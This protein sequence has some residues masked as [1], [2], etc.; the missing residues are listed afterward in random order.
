MKINQSLMLALQNKLQISV[1]N[2]SYDPCKRITI[3]QS[4][5]SEN[6]KTKIMLSFA[7]FTQDEKHSPQVTLQW[8]QEEA[9]F[10]EKAKDVDRVEQLLQR[11]WSRISQIFLSRQQECLLI[12]FSAWSQIFY[13]RV[14]H[15]MIYANHGIGDS[16]KWIMDIVEKCMRGFTFLIVSKPKDNRQFEGNY[17]K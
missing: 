16:G 7:I 3:T 2:K 9:L 12:R 4:N 10:T 14:L 1:Q 13:H 8:V 15:S 6:M 5:S 17:G 11:S